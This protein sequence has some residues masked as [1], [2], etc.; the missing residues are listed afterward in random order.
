VSGSVP[1][2]AARTASRPLI[3]WI[4][5]AGFAALISAPGGGMLLA[6]R[7][8]DTA[9][10]FRNPA[11]FPAVALHPAALA[12]FPGG[13]EAWFDDHIALRRPLIRSHSVVRVGVF[14]LSPHHS[15][16]VGEDGWLYRGSNEAIAC[17]RRDDPFT[18]DELAAWRAHLESVRDGL[19][20]VGVGF[21]FLIAPEKSSIHPEHMPPRLAPVS[22]RPSR[23]DQLVEYLGARSTLDVI[24]PRAAL[25]AG[26]RGEDVYFPTGVHWNEVG[27]HIAY[28]E[29]LPRIARSVA[30]LV[31]HP[32][33]AFEESAGI[34]REEDLGRRIELGE[35]YGA[36]GPVLTL[37]GAPPIQ[38]DPPRLDLLGGPVVYTN[39]AGPATRLVVLRDSFA[40]NLAPYLSLHFG[41]V[42]L[43]G[44]R[45]IPP[46]KLADRLLQERPT[47]V[48]FELDELELVMR[49]PPPPPIAWPELR[50]KRPSAAGG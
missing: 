17:Y 21:S 11:K 27:A 10:E 48:L 31:P 45:F 25:L 22:G 5:I 7:D 18:E 20:K 35:W 30:G 13:F 8:A 29:T 42:T 38:V 9:N 49:D 4:Q 40:D 14:G 23:C 2:Q 24:D 28:L 19:A 41:K 50:G 26:K 12:S 37:P 36:Y 32:R 43:L 34:D 1:G 3:D 47:F 15:V 6:S 46:E 33:E 44:T 16:L 39:P